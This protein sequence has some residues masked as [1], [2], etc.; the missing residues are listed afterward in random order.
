MSNLLDQASIVLTPTAYDNGKVL[1]AKPTDGSGDFDFSRNS[2]A[3]RVNAQGLVEDVQILSSNLVQN[4]DFSQTGSEEVTNGSFA[5]GNADWTIENTWT[6]GEGVANGNGANGSTAELKQT[7]VNTIGKSY[8]ATFKVLNYVSGS[9]GFFRGSGIGVTPRTADGVYTEYFTATSSEIRFRGSNFNG[10]ITNISV[11]EVGQNWFKDANWSIGDNVATSTGAGRMFQ[12]ISALEGNIGTKVK[13]SFNITEVTSGGVKV[14]CYGAT[15]AVITEVG[16]HTFTGTTTNTLNLYINNSGT[17]NLVGSITNISVIEITDDTN[18]PRI[19]YEGFSFQDA[20]GSELVLNGDFATNSDWNLGGSDTPIIENGFLKF[21]ISDGT[22]SRARQNNASIIGNC[23]VTY[24][25]VNS[26]ASTLAI[27]EYAGGNNESVPATIGTHTI[28]KNFIA[29][30]ISFQAGG[31]DGGILEIDNISVRE[32]LGQEVVPDSGCGN[33]LWEPQSTN[34]I[35]YSEDFTNSSWTKFNSSITNDNTKIL[36]INALK[37]V[38]DNNLKG[39]LK[40]PATTPQDGLV[41]N[42]SV[43]IKF[44]GERYVVLSAQDALSSSRSV[45]FDFTNKDFSYQG[46]SVSNLLAT[47]MGNEIFRISFNSISSGSVIDD[48]SIGFSSDGTSTSSF[49]GN[50]VDG[51]YATATQVEQQSYAT[52]YIPTDGTSVTRNQDLCTNGGSAA[53]INI[54]EG[55]LYAEIAALANDGTVRYLGLSDG[56]TN[57]RVIILYYSATNKVRAIV[58]SGGTK[59]VD[60]NYQLTNILDF[61]KVAIKYKLNDFAFWIDGVEVA[62]DT[63]LNAPIVLDDLSFSIGGSS[64]FFGK[65]KAV[66]V[67]KET[68]TDTELAE[69]TTI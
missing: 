49:L 19:N 23:K 17:G 30:G 24:T 13:V 15:S 60:V 3:T 4:G 34:I 43:Y 18:L 40:R 31:V 59:Y 1:C 26:S 64:P 11:K 63:S 56:S 38:P 45:I 28:Y 55:V 21:G 27:R 5:N 54:T 53:S 6:I 52:S 46:G 33:W 65:T 37:I 16:T 42:R 12:S 25:V 35:T 39:I 7:S 2:A 47:D 20:L 10:S 69:L 61:H 14:D 36:G 66:A 51:V 29:N 22:Y 9:V 68:L 8:K 32:V 58:S 62:T 67:W 50:G 41:Y 48:Y 44:G 57:N